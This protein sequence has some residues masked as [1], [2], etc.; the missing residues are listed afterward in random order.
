VRK[1]RRIIGITFSFTPLDMLT[2]NEVLQQERYRII[3]QLDTDTTG[4][5]YEAY[6]NNLETNVILKEINV[7]LGKVTTISQIDK[8][9]MAFASEAKILTEIKHQSLL[10]VQGYFSEIDRQYLVLESVGG[11]NLLEWLGRQ[12]LPMAITDLIGCADQ[13]IDVIHCLHTRTPPVIHCDINPQNIKLAPNGKIKLLAL[14]IAKKP[15]ERENAIIKNQASPSDSLHYLP[16]EQ[17]WGG[18]NQASKKVILNNYDEES[19][20][21]L[22]QPVDARSD[23][24]LSA[25]RSI[26]WRRCEFRSMRSNARLIF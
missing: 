3:K 24:S 12:K 18:L 20:R 11:D 22:E 2:T 7:N 21:V 10:Q 13:L 23:I 16:L 15:E 6:D 9:R 14:D 1:S 8:R 5:T 19:E 4:S 26:I 17:I 25:R